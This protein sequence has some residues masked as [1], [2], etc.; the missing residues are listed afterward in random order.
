MDI[1][2]TPINE[3]CVC[4]SVCLV[5]DTV[6]IHLSEIQRPFVKDTYD[7]GV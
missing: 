2:V 1:F 4:V 5:T 3:I 7:D 6:L